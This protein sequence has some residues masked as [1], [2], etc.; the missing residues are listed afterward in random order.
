MAE[1]GEP[2]SSHVAMGDV[3]ERQPRPSSWPGLGTVTA[4]VYP[5]QGL[6]WL[7]M[8]KHAKPEK[9]RSWGSSLPEAAF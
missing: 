9:G 8:L 4:L 6:D 1:P 5:A 7:Y 2:S 3:P